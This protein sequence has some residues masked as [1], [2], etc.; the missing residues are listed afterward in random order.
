VKKPS[1]S[2]QKLV[3][4]SAAHP[5]RTIGAWIVLLVAITLLGNT[6]A[7]PMTGEGSS[8]TNNPDSQVANELIE[9]HI[10]KDTQSSETI[11]VHSDTYTVDDPQFRE[12]V[13]NTMTSLESWQDEFASVTNY[14][15][16]EAAG[17][18]EADQLVSADRNSLVIPI[19]LN[20]DDDAYGDE[21]GKDFIE[22]SQAAATDQIEV[23]AVGDISGSATFGTIAEEDLSKEVSIGLPVAGIVLLVVFGALIA[24]ILPLAIGLVSIATTTG[25]VMLLANL[26]VLDDTTMSL[27]SMIGLA[28]GIDYALFFFERFREERRNGA[29]KRDAIERSGASAGKAIMFSGATV[30][31]ALCGLLL[32]PINFFQAMGVS[33]AM[34]VVVAVAAA[35][36]LLPAMVRLIGDWANLP[37][38]GMIRKLRRQDRTGYREFESRIGAGLW[39]H[40]AS[41]VMRRPVVWMLAS[42]AILLALAAPVLTMNIG[43]Q[44]SSS[45]PDTDYKR[46]FLI[47]A[48]DFSAGM[49]APVQIVVDGDANDTSVQAEV[50]AFVSALEGDDRFG[51]VATTVSPDGRLTVIDAVTKA[52]PYSHDAEDVVNDLR[53]N[54]VPTTFA[55]ESDHVFITGATAETIDFD[56]ALID[57]LPK[58]FA[59]VLGLSF[60]LLLVAFRS[61]LVPLTSILMNMLSVGAAYGAVVAVFQHGFLADAFGFTQVDTITDWLPVMLFCILFGLSM[62]YHVFLLS[63]V[64]EHFDHTGDNDEAVRVGLQQT[65]RLI[66]GAA[67]IMVAVFGSFAGGRLV[68]MQQMGFGLAFAVLIDAT[69]IRTILVP[70]T[71]KVFGKANWYMP[72]FLRWLPDFRVEGNL[73]PIKLPKKPAAWEPVSPATGPVQRP[74]VAAGE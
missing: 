32:L 64:R 9:R 48:E 73:A 46:G 62:D 25:L 41:A 43:T 38:F 51:S 67:L 59:F 49:E 66:T 2:P 52:D 16:L 40:L 55:T 14:Y 7:G 60:I 34:V 15:D 74:S 11:V 47:L 20:G 65:G 53:D 8:F 23:Y 54:V 18:P 17:A 50:A 28:V 71:L 24:P 19:T 3:S 69:L 63:R 58:V 45:L 44:E 39:G 6:F 35:M 37:R 4:A 21:E 72:R 31:F 29:L 1:L 42:L 26:L 33:T 27:V 13:T 68:E 12:V 56:T 36:T 5:W 10:G 57:S 22:R 61:I 70:A 30:I